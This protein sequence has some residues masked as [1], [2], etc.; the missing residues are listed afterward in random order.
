MGVT[1]QSGMVTVVAISSWV[2]LQ[3]RRTRKVPAVPEPVIV[4]ALSGVITGGTTPV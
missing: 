3:S 1:Q 4:P 2:T